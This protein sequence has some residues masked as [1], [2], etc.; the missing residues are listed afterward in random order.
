MAEVLGEPEADSNGEDRP[1]EQR[2]AR[3]MRGGRVRAEGSFGPLNLTLSPYT[4]SSSPVRG[5][6][7]G[8]DVAARGIS[9]T[10]DL[11]LGA[12]R[13][14]RTICQIAAAPSR[15]PIFFPSA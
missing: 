13:L 12:R 10:T 2:V 8:P 11:G 3:F 14:N 1:H 6:A 5:S 9:L 4:R 7:S 15:Q